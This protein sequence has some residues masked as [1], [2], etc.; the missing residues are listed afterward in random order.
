M[1]DQKV[2]QERTSEP[3][4]NILPSDVDA[5]GGVVLWDHGPQ[6]YVAVPGDTEEQSA[7]KKEQHD[8]AAAEWKA[9]HGDAPVPQRMHQA[10]A[11]H[12]MSVEPDRYS[13]EPSEL[14]EGEIEKRMEEIRAKRQAAI[15]APQ[16]ALDRKAAIESIMSDRRAA[17]TAAAV[18]AGPE[19][20]PLPVQ[21]PAPV[22]TVPVDSGPA[23]LFQTQPPAEPET[24]S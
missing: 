4:R 2:S 8:R 12:A 1:T 5:Q 19:V 17:T 3:R 23:P 15:D 11:S 16:I 10:D 18:E 20:K 6:E 24:H 7:A 22:V 14:D 9:A 21:E 13:M